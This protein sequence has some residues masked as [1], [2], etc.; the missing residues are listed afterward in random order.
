MRAA[1]VLGLPLYALPRASPLSTLLPPSPRPATPR[2]A[3][4]PAGNPSRLTR[5]QD[6]PSSGGAYPYPSA[7]GTSPEEGLDGRALAVVER[8]GDLGRPAGYLIDAQDVNEAIQ[9]ASKIPP[10]RLGS[11]EVRPLR[12]LT[13]P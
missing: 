13:Q 5:S 12:E 9:V 7:V 11:V 6:A 2:H 4:D 8:E 1:P 3:A 10:A